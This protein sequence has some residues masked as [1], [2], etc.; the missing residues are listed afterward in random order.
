MFIGQRSVRD[1]LIRTKILYLFIII[2]LY[3]QNCSLTFFKLYYLTYFK[4]FT[5]KM[6]NLTIFAGIL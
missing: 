1:I 3:N 5:I 4:I 6:N 2:L